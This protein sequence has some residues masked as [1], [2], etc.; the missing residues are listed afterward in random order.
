MS[1]AIYEIS[2]KMK[3]ELYRKI[4]RSALIIL[5]TLIIIN[6]ILSFVIFPVRTASDSM[7]PDIPAGAFEFVTP[8]FT[9]PDRGDVILLNDAAEEETSF[10][11][12][13]ANSFCHFVTFGQ[14]K[15]FDADSYF[16]APHIRRVI[17][18]PGDTIYLDRYDVYIMPEGENH[19]L[20]EFELTH[21]AYNIS[22]VDV[23]P[24]WDMT[25][26]TKGVTEKITLGDDE[27]FVLG[28]N[29]TAS[30]DSRLWGTVSED[31]ILGTVILQYFPFSKF[32]LF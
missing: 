15:P 16:A 2:Y 9:S 25:L 22:F 8:L 12:K 27:Y 21:S 19:F 31:S 32:R 29:R 11:Q 26:G 20:T 28:D 23:P 1:R 7:E 18:L 24:D 30:S 6:L 14:W 5:S 10:F 13:I 17:G 4:T 3:K